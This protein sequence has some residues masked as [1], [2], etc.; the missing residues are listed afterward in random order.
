[1][2]DTDDLDKPIYGAKAIGEARKLTERQAFWALENGYLDADKM[3]RKWTST[4][5]RLRNHYGLKPKTS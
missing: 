5:R 4:P 2:S 3:G 1:M